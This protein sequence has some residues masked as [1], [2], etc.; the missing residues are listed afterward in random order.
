MSARPFSIFFGNGD[1]V[2][3]ECLLKKR[4]MSFPALLFSLCLVTNNIRSLYAS[5][6]NSEQASDSGFSNPSKISGS[7]DDS[8]ISSNL[9]QGSL[10]IFRILNYFANFRYFACFLYCQMTYFVLHSHLPP[11]VIQ[12]VHSK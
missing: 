1:F 5:L 10:L 12:L 7:S 11:K 8:N 4:I 2:R 6:G 9:L 3:F